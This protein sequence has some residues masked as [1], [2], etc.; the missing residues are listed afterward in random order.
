MKHLSLA[1]LVIS[2]ILFYL[3]PNNPSRPFMG[4]CVATSI[5]LIFLHIKGYCIESNLKNIYLRHSTLFLLFFFVVFFQRATDFSLGI[6]NQKS[7]SV[8][9]VLWAYVPSVV[10]KASALSLL[11]LSAFLFGYHCY[12]AKSL[13]ISNCKYSYKFTNKRI[14]VLS[15]FVLLLIYVAL[16]GIGDFSKHSE[17]ENMG[18]LIVAQAVLLAIVV[19][20]SYEYKNKFRERKLKYIY[21]LFPLSLIIFYLLI[22]FATGNR[23]G[24]IKVCLM[25]L[26]AYIYIVRDK[27][28]YKRVLAL[29]IVG[30]FFMTLIGIIRVQDTK[31]INE[32]YSLIAAK[33]TVLPLTAELSGS[34]NTVHVVLANVP[35]KQDYNLGSSFISGFS[36]LIPGLSRFTSKLIEPSGETI[37]K[38][39]FGGFKP[40]W[41]WGLGSSCIADSYISFGVVGT[42]IIFFFLGRFIH[43]LE[44]GTFIVDKSPYFLVLSFCVF[45]QLHSL[46]RGPFSILFLSWDYA[47]LLVFI[48]IRRYKKAKII[49][50]D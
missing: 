15:G 35:Q 29:S 41:G 48:F 49:N 13:S 44:L 31:N 11:S 33:E 47:V 43:Y 12:N 21:I 5:F 2:L 36:V 50:N 37:T 26:I 3:A 34:V 40:D 45:S 9:D 10:S 24:A 27:V 25:L 14:L 46:C 8:Y 39:Y 7:T 4:A 18:F 6:I 22:Y 17:D 23:G 16:T 19:I 32:A 1:V 30:A 38:M 28:N 20:Y 42:I